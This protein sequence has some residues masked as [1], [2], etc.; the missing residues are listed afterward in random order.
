MPKAAAQKESKRKPQNKKQRREVRRRRCRRLSKPEMRRCPGLRRDGG[1]WTSPPAGGDIHMTQNFP[2]VTPI[3]TRQITR[4][5]VEMCQRC[6][7]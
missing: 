6:A 7:S 3:S 5:L 2:T 1:C 4:Q